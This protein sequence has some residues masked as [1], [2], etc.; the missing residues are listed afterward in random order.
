MKILFAAFGTRGD[1]QPL[2]AL[3]VSLQATGH[4]PIVCAPP[5]FASWIAALGLEVHATGSDFEVFMARLNGNMLR[6]LSLLRAEFAAQFE[7]IEAQA[8]DVDCIIG[9][10][11]HIAGAS[12]A[13]ARGIP[14]RYVAFTPTL[15]PSAFHPAPVI[16]SQTLPRALNRLSWTALRIL[17]NTFFRGRIDQERRRLGVPP[18]KDLWDHMLGAKPICAFDPML[19]PV[20]EDATGR[21]TAPTG[22][23][24]LD[25]PEL[26]PVIAQWARNGAAPVYVGFGSM[27][28]EDPLRTTRMAIE[29]ARILG[30]RMIIAAGWAKLGAQDL[31]QSIRVIDGAPHRRL[32]PLCS[33]VVHHGGAGTT[34]AAA[35]SGVPQVVIP[36]LLDQ[37]YF[38]HRLAVLGAA[39][40]GL[41]RGRFT[42][43]RFAA[44]LRLAM[45][46]EM[47][48]K[49]REFALRMIRD[50]LARAVREIAG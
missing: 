34:H 9:S 46:D 1:V 31:P 49:A 4:T 37:H 22:A 13:E 38:A 8:K 23:W 28:D 35:F 19:A 17:L 24:L 6:G 5:N 11:T 32:F 33:A 20:P 15:L 2:L 43:E 50:G 16:Q 10:A 44:A 26:D 45:S 48:T 41:A 12:V 36:H 7:A 47:R 21:A 25:E 42:A 29:A 39:P 40:A 18:L 3:A 30:V 27:Y 14:Y